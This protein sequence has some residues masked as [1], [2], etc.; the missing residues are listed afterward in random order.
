[1]IVMRMISPLNC[2]KIDVFH[3]LFLDASTIN[4]ISACDCM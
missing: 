2:P 1:M 4:N 3:I